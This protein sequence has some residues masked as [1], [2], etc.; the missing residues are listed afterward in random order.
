MT[1]LQNKII[2]VF[3]FLAMLSSTRLEA[4]KIDEEM[5]PDKVYDLLGSRSFITS[6]NDLIA[7]FKQDVGAILA[8]T[9]TS[10]IT[11][12]SQSENLSKNFKNYT[13]N[14]LEEA[15][16]ANKLSMVKCFECMMLRVEMIRSEPHV[17]KGITNLT[18]LEKYLK[19]YRTN[20]YT[21]IHL[22]Y[23]GSEL[24]LQVE[25][26]SGLEKTLL[27]TKEYRTNVYS[28]KEEGLIFGIS[29][30]MSYFPDKSELGG[31]MGGMFYLGH[32]MPRL[33]E[34][35]IYAAFVGLSNQQSFASVGLFLDLDVNDIFKSY[36]SLGIL[37]FSTRFG[38]SLYRD[39]TNFHGAAG[40][41]MSLFTIY[42]IFVDYQY[43]LKIGDQKVL[44]DEFRYLK[45]SFPASINIGMGLDF[46]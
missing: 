35:G 31:A 3:F 30:M 46:G 21:E 28:L 29:A 44:A 37:Y 12:Y 27:F 34:T 23:V 4:K 13:L 39:E 1:H 18:E 16:I 22:S 17:K 25:V 5:L 26:L 38:A 36:W 32:R 40:L 9:R 11:A 45:K 6:I 33:A 41:K 20:S 10:L 8:K 43:N 42:H 24:I 19:Q 2:T 14:K 15:A 7:N